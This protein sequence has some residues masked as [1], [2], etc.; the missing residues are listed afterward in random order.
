MNDLPQG[1]EF[2]AAQLELDAFV[3]ETKRLADERDATDAQYAVLD[4]QDAENAVTELD[5]QLIE[6]KDKLIDLRA[7]LEW[8][9]SQYY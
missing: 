3:A 1:A 4:K 7:Q 6:K 5:R 9:E 8:E 2:D